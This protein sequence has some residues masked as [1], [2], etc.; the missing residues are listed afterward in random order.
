MY[1]GGKRKFL[2]NLKYV[3]VQCRHALLPTASY[4]D[5]GVSL[6]TG[7]IY[8]VEYSY[9]YIR[10]ALNKDISVIRESCTIV[11]NSTE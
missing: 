3:D 11:N 10:A 6:T 2:L 4:I 5:V 7:C 1:G 8:T 9:N